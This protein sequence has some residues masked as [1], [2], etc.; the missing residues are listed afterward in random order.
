MEIGDDDVGERI[1]QT[2]SPA[3]PGA[4]ESD[5]DKKLGPPS[6]IFRFQRFPPQMRC[7]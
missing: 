6:Q 2:V 5:D 4:G 1:Q 3:A 7:G